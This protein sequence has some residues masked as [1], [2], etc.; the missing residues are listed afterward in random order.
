PNGGTLYPSQIPSAGLERLKSLPQLA[1]LD[2][3]YTRATT[4]GVDALRAALPRCRIAYVGQ[5]SIAPP[6]GATVVGTNVAAWV[7]AMGGK[8]AEHEGRI[9]EISLA[10]T[11]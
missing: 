1:S 4:A 8:V 7:K 2:V 11:A 9:T 3:R 6:R 5:P 10:S